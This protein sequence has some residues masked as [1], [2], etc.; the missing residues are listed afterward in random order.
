MSKHY[1]VSTPEVSSAYSYEE[2][3]EDFTIVEC[4]EAK[5]KADARAKF[6]SKQYKEWTEHTYFSR[7]SN[8]FYHLG[9]NENPYRGL[10]VNPC[11]CEH[12]VCLCE[13]M[14]CKLGLPRSP[15]SDWCDDCVDKGNR[16]HFMEQHNALSENKCKCRLNLE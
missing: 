11:M 8:W 12:G 10:E 13:D 9:K 2:P 3:Q 1:W 15:S 16:E 6:V 4:V 7:D 14:E 5:S